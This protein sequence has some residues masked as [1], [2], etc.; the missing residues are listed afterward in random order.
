[1][2]P[3]PRLVAALAAALHDKQVDCSRPPELCPPSW[4]ADHRATAADILPAFLADPRVEA[5]LAERLHATRVDR[6]CE[7]G[8][9]D[10]IY[11]HEF[12][13]AAILGRQP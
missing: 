10:C 12:N 1:M 3:D 9:T 4:M 5:W 13:A 6:E 2:T 11:A 7:P 8:D